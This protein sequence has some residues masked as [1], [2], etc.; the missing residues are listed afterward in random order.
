MLTTISSIALIGGRPVLTTDAL[1]DKDE[2]QALCDQTGAEGR[3]LIRIRHKE[4]SCVAAVGR[5]K[6]GEP[7]VSPTNLVAIPCPPE[8]PGGKYSFTSDC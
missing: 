5:S 7:L 1:F 8:C 2:L 3:T 6:K 4:A